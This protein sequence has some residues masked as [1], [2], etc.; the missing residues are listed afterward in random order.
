MASDFPESSLH[1]GFAHQ[2]PRRKPGRRRVL[3]TPHPQTE[4][5][6]KRQTAGRADGAC[7]GQAVFR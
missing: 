5:Y 4:G 6:L 1:T 2:P 7:L 3:Q